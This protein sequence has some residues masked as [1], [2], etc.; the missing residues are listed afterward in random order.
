VAAVPAVPTDRIRNVALLG[1]GGSGK[2]TLAE[3]LLAAHG[4]TD[5]MGRIE[6]RTT[7]CDFDPEEHAR[8]SSVSLAVAPFV[9]EHEGKPYKINLI[10][11]PGY[12]DFVADALAALR[13]ADLALFCVSATDGIGVQTEQL[14]READ[15]VG[16]P[17]AFVITKMDRERADYHQ[18]VDDLRDRF[19]QGVAPLQLPVGEGPELRGVV[20]LLDDVAHLYDGSAPRGAEAEVPD[21]LAEEEHRTHD[22]LVEGIVVADDE[23]MERY[24]AEEPIALAELAHALGDGVAASQVFPVLCTS[25]TRMTGIDLLATFLVEEAPP[26]AAVDGDTVTFVFKTLVDPYVGRINL[27]KV[28]QGS[29]KQD[30]HLVNGRTL[31]DERLHQLFHVRGKE[32]LP[33]S[34]VVPGDLAAVAKLSGAATGDVLGQRG[35]ALD[36]APLATPDATLPIAIHAKSKSDEDKLATALHKLQDEDAVL[37]IE[38]DPETHQTVLWGVGEAHLQISIDRLTRKF[39]VAVDTDDVRVRYRE[40]VTAQAEA[41]GRHKKQSGGHGQFGVCSL[42]VAPL[43]RGGGFEFHDAIVGGVIPK[44]FLPAIEKGVVEVMERGGVLGFPVVDVSVTCFDGKYHA[45]DSSEMS[46]K[47]AGRL[48][49]RGALAKAGPVLLEPITELVVTAPTQY[50]GDVM[51]DF[52]AKRGRVTGTTPV[53]DGEVEISA[54]VPTSEVLRYAIDLRSMTQGRGRFTARHAHYDPVPA[55]L[56]DKI[57]RDVSDLDE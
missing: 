15:A 28:L 19:G 14:W 53:G 16:I 21:D 45:V 39:G 27:F 38:R 52:N 36:V 47:V 11:V 24:L 35:A 17:R 41:E 22:A 56:V 1:H 55:H 30:D 57:K 43:A 50:Q 25:A 4:A 6:D 9:V 49:F 13:V 33:T 26:P 48:A 32:Q 37:R 31:V 3:A 8:G 40:T 54:H 2:T 44:G 12:P 7:V 51:G 5:R 20:S 29:L 18:V 34:E 42:R 23:M 10:D 46:F